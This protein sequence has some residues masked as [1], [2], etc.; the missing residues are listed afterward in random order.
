MVKLLCEAGI[1]PEIPAL[2]R[3]DDWNLLLAVL[4]ILPGYGAHPETFLYIKNLDS[5]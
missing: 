2:L 1:H 5:L 3:K 4:Q